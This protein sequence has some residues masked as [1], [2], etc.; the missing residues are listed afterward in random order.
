MVQRTDA[1]V[2]KGLWRF[3]ARHP[4]WTP[5]EGGEDGWEPDVAWWA[6]EVQG[7]VLLID[8]LVDDWQ[9]L[10]RL[11]SDRGGCAGV[12]RTC[13]WHERSIEAVA[14]RYDVGV[15]AK[16]HPTEPGHLRVDHPVADRD[17]PFEGVHVLDVER[18][19]EIALWLS[20]QRALVFGDAM[21]RRATGELRVCPPSWTQPEGGPARLR[22]LLGGLAALGP[23]HVF[24]SHGPL[25]VGDGM[26]SLQAATA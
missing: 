9:G 5:E 6:V 17:E 19:D 15:W 20:R 7:G 12:V 25:V 3:Q 13:H 2:V 22:G 18:A 24:V 23:E 21:L 16:P 26:A 11:L 10:D 8:P 4:E 14:T 1:E